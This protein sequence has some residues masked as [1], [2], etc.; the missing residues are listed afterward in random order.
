LSTLLNCAGAVGFLRVSL[1]Q[2][3]EYLHAGQSC[4]VL[5]GQVATSAPRWAI[6]GSSRRAERP[7]A[8]P[9]KQGERRRHPP[10]ERGQPFYWIPQPWVPQ[11]AGLAELREIGPIPRGLASV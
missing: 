1:P 9:C 10:I 3:A 8:S 2:G 4:F 11:V 5:A 7:M 6:R